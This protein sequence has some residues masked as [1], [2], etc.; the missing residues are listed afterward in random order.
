MAYSEND[1][2]K[3]IDLYE[4]GMPRAKIAKKEG[5][6]LSTIRN[7]TKE[8]VSVPLS[9]LTCPQC[10]RRRRRLNIQQKYC[11]LPCKNA[12]AYRRS[13]QQKTAGTATQDRQCRHC[14]QDY[15][16]KHDNARRY[17]SKKCRQSA[18]NQ[19]RKAKLDHI[20]EEQA[21]KQARIEA[22]Q[23]DIDHCI[24]TLRAAKLKD[25]ATSRIDSSK[26]SAEIDTLSRF[27]EEGDPTA[28]AVECDSRSFQVGEIVLQRNH[29]FDSHAINPVIPRRSSGIFR[30]YDHRRRKPEKSLRRSKE[31]FLAD[32]FTICCWHGKRSVIFLGVIVVA[33]SV[34]CF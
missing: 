29:G 20:K 9:F 10:K 8:T 11:S 4:S 14:G 18:S 3:V 27:I 2:S 25:L 21:A 19:R 33:K 30:S 5:I 1:K 7:W 17:C 6:S 16:P 22:K 15:T 24:E 32:M 13:V 31:S 28:G 34:H 12:A 23:Q 26:Y